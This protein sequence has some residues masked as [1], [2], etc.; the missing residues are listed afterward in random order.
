MRSEAFER[1]LAW[2]REFLRKALAG[3]SVVTPL[4]AFVALGRDPSTYGP[5]HAEAICAVLAG[6]GARPIEQDAWSL[7]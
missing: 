1:S 5:K 3:R 6:I 2:R 7:G 4:E